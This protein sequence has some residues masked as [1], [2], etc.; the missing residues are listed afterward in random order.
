MKPEKKS[1]E[2]ESGKIATD[3]LQNIGEQKKDGATMDFHNTWVCLNEVCPRDC[4]KE[5]MNKICKSFA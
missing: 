4:R 1:M 3:K 2:E 5:T